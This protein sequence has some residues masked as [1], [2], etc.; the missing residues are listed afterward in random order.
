VSD[1]D[2]LRHVAAAFGRDRITTALTRGWL[3]PRHAGGKDRMVIF[4]TEETKRFMKCPRVVALLDSD[5]CY[6]GH[7][8]R[9]HEIAERLAR[10]G[11]PAHVL[12]LREVENYVPNLILAGLSPRRVN[13]RVLE[14]LKT[15]TPQ[16]RGYFDMKAGFGPVTRDPEVKPAQQELYS[17][18]SPRIRRDLRGGFGNDLIHEM[19]RQLTRT[20]ARLAEEDFAGVSD[21][22]ETV[23]ELRSL[24]DMVESVI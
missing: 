15:L 6:P 3:E 11:V 24:L 5:S 16:Q 14:A 2:F 19:T 21:G 22:A 17:G 20:G 7:R 18:L 1:A 9:C 4:A 8:T 10:S 13:R 23:D 12:A